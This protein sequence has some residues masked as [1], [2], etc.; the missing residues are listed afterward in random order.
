M[1]HWN[2]G[3][4]NDPDFHWVAILWDDSPGIRKH[5]MGRWVVDNVDEDTGDVLVPA[6]WMMMGSGIRVGVDEVVWWNKKIKDADPYIHLT[7]NVHEG[8]DAEDA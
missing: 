6:S 1:A 4:P 3:I 2:H 5:D 8:G 7:T